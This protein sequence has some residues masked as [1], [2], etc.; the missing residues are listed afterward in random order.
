MAIQF[1]P[2][3]A[4]HGISNARDEMEIT[5]RTRSGRTL[6]DAAL[7]RLADDAEKGFD[8]SRWQPRRGRPSLGASGEHSPRVSARVPEDVY[9]RAKVRASA[10]GKSVSEVVRELLGVY[11]GTT[12]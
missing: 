7:D 6:T 8:L 9:R 3:A 5:V 4:R 1:R 2:S 10:E 12:R 11:V